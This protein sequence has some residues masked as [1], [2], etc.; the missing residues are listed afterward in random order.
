[1]ATTYYHTTVSASGDVALA[2]EFEIKRIPIGLSAN[3]SGSI[4]ANADLA[5]LNPTY[6]FATPV[7]GGQAAVGFL[8][9][10]GRTSTSLAATLTGALTTPFGTFP[11]FRSDSISD[12][13][14]GFGDL[15]PQASLRWNNGVHNWMT[16]ITGDV[17]VGGR[18][19]VFV[20]TAVD[21]ARELAADDGQKPFE[22]AAEL[23]R[24]KC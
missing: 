9:I 7:L 6:V 24:H 22:G 5:L 14:W 16:Y 3:L 4:N 12:S 19:P 17:P 15:I 21:D 10:Y 8:G 23:C 11:F 18:I 1:M 13:A 20:I 2:R